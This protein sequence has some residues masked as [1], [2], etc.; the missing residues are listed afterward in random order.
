MEYE[1]DIS[2]RRINRNMKELGL[3][4]VYKRK[5]YKSPKSP[6]VESTAPNLLDRN[7]R[8]KAPYEV[9]VSDLTYARVKSRWHYVCILLDLHNR[10]IIGYSAGARKDAALVRTA[11]AAV[12]TNLSNIRMFHSDRGSEYDNQL[13]DDLLEVF[14]INRSL[15]LKGCPYD[16]A[17]SEA[18]FKM[19]K[20]EFI[21]RHVFAS[22]EELK[23]ELADYV[24]WYNNERPHSSLGYMTP[25]EYKLKLSQKNCLDKC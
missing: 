18:T 4:S 19:I 15:S 2:V 13:I 20:Q 16:N 11:F 6:A 5:R 8:D 12:K 10:E 17:V 24:E 1:L 23:R 22:L 7:F 14:D 21:Y 3:E 9:V 25:S